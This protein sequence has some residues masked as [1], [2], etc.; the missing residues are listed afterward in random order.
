[1]G[2]TARI[3]SGLIGLA[4]IAFVLRMTLFGASDRVLID[5]ALAESVQAGKEGRPGGVLEYLSQSFTFNSDQLVDRRQVAD[6]I[7][8]AKPDV[9]LGS[10]DPEIK[11]D[12]AEVVTSAHVKVSGFGQSIDRQIPKVTIVLQRENATKWLVFPSKQWRVVSVTAP[13]DS[14]GDILPSF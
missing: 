8:K 13:A 10:I 12:S 5:E 11:G 7:R 4:L 3:V 2:K 14:L 1:M 6:F 9:T